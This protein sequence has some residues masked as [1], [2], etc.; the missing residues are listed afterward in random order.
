VAVDFLGRQIYLRSRSPATGKI[1]TSGADAVPG[2]PLQPPEG[3]PG[4][5]GSAENGFHPYYHHGLPVSRKVEEVRRGRKYTAFTNRLGFRDQKVRGVD[6]KKTGRRIILIGDS[7]ILGVGLEWDQTLAGMLQKQFANVEVLNAAVPSY[8]PTSEESKLRYLMGRHGLEADAV[9]LFLDVAD[10]DDELQYGRRTDGSTFLIGPQFSEVPEN[11][12]WADH[13]EKFLQNRLENNFTVV[14]AIVRN[15]RQWL[16]RHCAWFGVM[17]YEKGRWSEYRGHL[18]PL[19]DEGILRAATSLTRLNEFL[20][21]KNVQMVLVISPGSSQ[22]D[23][24]DS[25]SRAIVIWEAWGRSNEVP[26]ASLFPLFYAHAKE[27]SNHIQNSGHWNEKGHVLVAEEL[28]QQLPS[29][30]PGLLAPP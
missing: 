28:F 20:K 22:M 24:L 25:K 3:D 18:D 12:N 5:W 7:N 26:V 10:V 19:I 11:K 29:R 1:N 17:A 8:C 4:Y 21:S 14:G 15:V 9:V 2:P 16:R 6:L 27:Y 30:L 23:L 13:M